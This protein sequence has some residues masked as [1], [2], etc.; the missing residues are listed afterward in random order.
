VSIITEARIDHLAWVVSD[1]SLD[2][3]VE[4]V[5]E[6]L[7]VRF[8]QH[9]GPRVLG[10]DTRLSITFEAGLEFVAPGGSTLMARRFSETLATK[11]ET[12]LL[13]SIRVPRVE[14]AIAAL[15][16]V[17]VRVGDNLLEPNPDARRTALATWAGSVVDLVEHPVIAEFPRTA[18]FIIEVEYAR[19]PPGYEQHVGRI[20]RVTWLVRHENAAAYV[21]LL[22][23]L[24]GAKFERDHSLGSE[25]VSYI[26]WDSGLEV[27]APASR[28]GA[29]ATELTN[30]LARRGEGM[31]SVAFGVDS[32]WATAS[33]AKVM[34]YAVDDDVAHR[35]GAYELQ[36]GDIADIKLI[37]SE[38]TPARRHA[39][40]AA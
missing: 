26:A 32:L 17:G 10:S 20:D 19:E 16:R 35:P 2:R 36:I 31:Y 38:P 24:F 21:E 9:P 4:Q 11:G 37:A 30:Q 8:L 33:R 25:V 18:F 29:L 13:C 34:G 15:E 39:G 28:S 6:L 22:E 27:V 23:S 5:T 1:D 7:D 12:A 14:E 40:R 3:Y